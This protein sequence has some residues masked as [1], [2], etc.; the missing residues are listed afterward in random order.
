MAITCTPRR[1]NDVNGTLYQ[2]PQAPKPK[3]E[4]LDK[5]YKKEQQKSTF[6]LKLDG[7]L[8]TSYL[9]SLSQ[10]QQVKISPELEE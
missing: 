7:D 6:L 2:K 3:C 5:P 10:S 8:K 4:Q 9:E 1:E